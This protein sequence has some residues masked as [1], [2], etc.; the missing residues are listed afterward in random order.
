MGAL[1]GARAARA[2]ARGYPRKI[3][4]TARSG[5]NPWQP[6]AGAAAQCET[7]PAR[8]CVPTRCHTQARFSRMLSK[9]LAYEPKTHWRPNVTPKSHPNPI[10]AQGQAHSAPLLAYGIGVN[11]SCDTQWLSRCAHAVCVGRIVHG[12]VC[13]STGISSYL[14]KLMPLAFLVDSKRLSISASSRAEFPRRPP[15]PP[16]PPQLTCKKCVP[17]QHRMRGSAREAS[18]QNGNAHTSRT[19]TRQG[20]KMSAGKIRSTGRVVTGRHQSHGR[21]G[22]QRRSNRPIDRLRS[23][24]LRRPSA[25]LRRR[26]RRRHPSGHRHLHGRHPSGHRRRRGLHPSGRRG[27]RRH[28][29]SD[30][31][32][33]H[34][35]GHRSGRR[36]RRLP[37]CGPLPPPCACACW[38]G[39]TFGAGP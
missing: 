10:L 31:R 3:S 19:G 14:S 25:H 1:E 18:R 7:G 8:Q 11:T 39:C 23:H 32:H 9:A 5:T 22:Q 21:R 38:A 34:L 20:H 26:G 28:R 6:H 30:R 12:Q 37:S 17:R 27:R 4:A 2:R 36:R 29:P 16:P 33:G 13:T 35:H 24:A 15:P